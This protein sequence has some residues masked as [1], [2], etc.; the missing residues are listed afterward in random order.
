MHWSWSRFAVTLVVALI[1]V[2]AYHFLIA[3]R[4]VRT[5]EVR[6]RVVEER[7]DESPKLQALLEGHDTA[8]RERDEAML[9]LR[10]DHENEFDALR[11]EHQAEVD[12]LHT[13][14]VKL[15]DLVTELEG[16]TEK[17]RKLQGQLSQQKDEYA[18]LEMDWKRRLDDATKRLAA[19]EAAR[20]TGA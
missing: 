6:E 7:N 8:L 17:A 1:V 16:A 20:T 12:A 15:R 10:A 18:R 3:P 5:E 11:R 4:L 2:L 14:N 9:R 19:A 13:E